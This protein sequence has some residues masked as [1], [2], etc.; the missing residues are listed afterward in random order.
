[1]VIGM[2]SESIKCGVDNIMEIK[3]R[4]IIKILLDLESQAK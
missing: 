3:F 1:M 2:E 4:M